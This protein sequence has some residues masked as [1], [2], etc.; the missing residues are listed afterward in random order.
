MKFITPAMHTIV[1]ILFCAFTAA[2]PRLFDFGG[3]PATLCYGLAIGYLVFALLTN[4][5]ASPIRVIPFRVHGAVEII[6]GIA[7]LSA[8][9]LFGFADHDR[10]K[11]YFVAAGIVTFVV[12]AL[13]QWR[14]EPVPHHGRHH[15]A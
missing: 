6:A 3:L 9:W 11:W 10:A 2:A 14:E 5:P 13:T 1:D 12:W 8:P 15:P 7:L 4:T